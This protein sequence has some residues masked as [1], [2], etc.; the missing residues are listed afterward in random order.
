[1]PRDINQLGKAI[2][3]DAMTKTKLHSRKH[4]NI[5]ITL[6]KNPKVDRKLL[7]E[8]IALSDELE[9]LGFPI[10]RHR[11]S[12]TPFGGRRVIRGTDESDSR[13]FHLP[14]IR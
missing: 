11:P 1:M 8:S 9:R 5:R 10:S 12:A 3:G 6:K 2:G 4:I 7:K 14:H 13:T